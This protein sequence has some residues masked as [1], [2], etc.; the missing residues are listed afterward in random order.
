MII[1]LKKRVIEI[2]F[3][4]FILTIVAVLLALCTILFIDYRNKFLGMTKYNLAILEGL[5]FVIYNVYEILMAKHYIYYNDEG[6]MLIFRY[7]HL[8]FFNKKKNAIEFP[9]QEFRGIEIK[10]SLM[11][12]KEEVIL[13]RWYKGQE[14]KY[15][16]VSL[17][18]MKKNQRENLLAHMQ[19]YSN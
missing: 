13:K 12:L 17:M 4:R 16:P 9:K 14:A 7:F 3:R 8:S 19:K 6:S 5:I 18:A 11:G 15:P 2:Q 1:D 10:K